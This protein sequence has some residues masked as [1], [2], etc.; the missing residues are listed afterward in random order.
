MAKVKSCGRCGVESDSLRDF[1]SNSSRVRE[2]L[3]E[4]CKVQAMENHGL[5]AEQVARENERWERIFQKFADPNYYAYRPIG[6]QSSFN[7]VASQME[8]LCGAFLTGRRLS[9]SSNI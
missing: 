1:R 2:R 5:S 4:S 9:A 8:T 3:C 7:A 6:M